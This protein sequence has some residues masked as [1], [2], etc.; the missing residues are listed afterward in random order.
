[1]ANCCYYRYCSAAGLPYPNRSRKPDSTKREMGLGLVLGWGLINAPVVLE[2]ADEVDTGKHRYPIRWLLY[3][4]DVL[5]DVLVLEIKLRQLLDVV[6]LERFANGRPL[7]V[8]VGNAQRRCCDSD[9]RSG[10]PRARPRNVDC[11]CNG[12]TGGG[13]N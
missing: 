12:G 1:M 6:E 3:R 11:R 13:C 2:C 8:L 9:R 10:C 7:R 4:I 5:V